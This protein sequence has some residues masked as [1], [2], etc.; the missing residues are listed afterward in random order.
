MNG[1]LSLLERNSIYIDHFWIDIFNTMELFLKID[2][3]NSYCG[4]KM[5][6]VLSHSSHQGMASI[7][8]PM[9]ALGWPYDLL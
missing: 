8:F 5:F 9:W 7:F 3:I 2:Q 1:G 4:L 6:T